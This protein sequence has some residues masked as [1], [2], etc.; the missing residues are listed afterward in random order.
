[1]PR[2]DEKLSWFTVEPFLS[3]LV[4]YEN[5]NCW[6]MDLA[7]PTRIEFIIDKTAHLHGAYV[8]DEAGN[9]IIHVHD[10][11]VSSGPH[12]GS[13][14]NKLVSRLGLDS[15]VIDEMKAAVG[16]S[17]EYKLIVSREADMAIDRT[18]NQ[19]T[20]QPLPAVWSVYCL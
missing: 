1:M 12:V 9:G 2:G 4:R 17:K 3:K 5:K 10:A 13:L 18:V 15:V 11:V 19:Y 6:P 14:A 7:P 20:D 8:Y 16:R